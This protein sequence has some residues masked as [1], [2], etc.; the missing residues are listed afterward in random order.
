MALVLSVTSLKTTSNAGSGSV[1]AF[2]TSTPT[3]VVSFTRGKGGTARPLSSASVSGAVVPPSSMLTPKRSRTR[4]I[5]LTMV[6]VSLPAKSRPTAW[7]SAS[8]V[9]TREPESPPALKA[10]PGMESCSPK[11]A[12]SVQ[13]SS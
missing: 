13:G 10:P 4:S 5:R 6:S 9:T 11:R 3:V 8:S 12:I 7:R 2:R 1:P